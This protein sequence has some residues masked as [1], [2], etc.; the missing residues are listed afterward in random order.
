MTNTL[1]EEAIE[2]VIARAAKQL[3]ALGV[4]FLI[5]SGEEFLT[6]Q[7]SKL[8]P[9]P[10]RMKRDG[11]RSKYIDDHL[12]TMSVGGD[13]VIPYGEFP[14]ETIKTV[15]SARAHAVFGKGNYITRTTEDGV[16]VL[17]LAIE[18]QQGNEEEQDAV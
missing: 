11:S 18:P 8:R 13:M 4:D 9:P 3:T 5:Q 7:Y 1:R 17:C 15:V 2:A 10:K 14:P 6:P 12:K 16:Y